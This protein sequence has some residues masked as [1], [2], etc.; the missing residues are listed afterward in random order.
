MMVWVLQDIETRLE[1]FTVSGKG[2]LPNRTRD[3]PGGRYF[4]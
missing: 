1:A 2:A 3:S 4:Y